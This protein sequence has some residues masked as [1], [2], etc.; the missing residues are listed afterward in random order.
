M[1][2]K[3]S[4]NGELYLM[5]YDIWPDKPFKCYGVP[6]G[7]TLVKMSVFDKIEKPYFS[8]EYTKEGIMKMSQDIYFCKKVNKAGLEVWCD[9]TLEVGHIG[10]YQY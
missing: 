8:F 10:S 9:P 3:Q 6:T 7:C 2:Y 5:N 4:D 1:I